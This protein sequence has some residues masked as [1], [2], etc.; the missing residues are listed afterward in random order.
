M[1][2]H[3]RML[4][5]AALA[6]AVFAIGQGSAWAADDPLA[7]ARLLYNR[8]EYREAVRAA[9]QARMTPARADAAD[10]VAARAYLE[11]FRETA[12]SD[13]LTNARDRL[14][15]IDPQKFGPRERGEYVV[16]L[17]EALFFEG[18]F[19][20]AATVFDSVLNGPDALAGEARE[21]VL[22]WWASAIDREAKPR[23]DI[24]RQGVYLRIRARMN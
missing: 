7:L 4:R 2:Y 20:A 23:P 3:R 1:C 16:G 6:A 15:R 8:G 19:G 5:V 18:A 17:G 10:L 21:R 11:R 14:R 13:D 12:A 22:D 24:E 9:E